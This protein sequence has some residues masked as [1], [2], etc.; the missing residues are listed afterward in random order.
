MLASLRTAATRI[1]RTAVLRRLVHTQPQHSGIPGAL[2]EGYNR[3]SQI[4]Q[5]KEELYNLIAKTP[6]LWRSPLPPGWT[7][8]CSRLSPCKSSL[9]QRTLSGAR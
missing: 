1:L 2:D 3:A 5:K 4:Q 9:D 6:R 8:D 7:G